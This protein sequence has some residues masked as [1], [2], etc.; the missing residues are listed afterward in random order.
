[1]DNGEGLGALIPP[2][3]G[4]D[5]LAPNRDRLACMVRNGIQDT[6][7]VKGK[8]YAEQMLGNDKLSDIQIA[9]VLN[10]VLYKWGNQIPPLTFEEVQKS[11]AVCKK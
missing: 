7:L 1:M 3:A 11:L 2:L 10:F 5:Y 6:I 4:S 8:V 9:N